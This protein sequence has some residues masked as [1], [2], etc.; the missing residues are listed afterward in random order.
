M[1]SAAMVG[2]PCDFT[3]DGGVP[4]PH[5]VG[6]VVVGLLAWVGYLC[7]M[8]WGLN[9]SCGFAHLGGVRLCHGVGFVVM[10]LLI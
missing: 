5:G 8:G 4:L 9:C 1:T 6:F 10:G 7:V 2:Y 3:H